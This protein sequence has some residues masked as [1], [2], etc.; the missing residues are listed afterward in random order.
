[1]LIAYSLL[2]LLLFRLL[3]LNDLRSGWLFLSFVQTVHDVLVFLDH[4]LVVDIFEAELTVVG[5][6]C[7]L[8]VAA[9]PTYLLLRRRAR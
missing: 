6:S 4:K 5:D 3:L 9:L 8:Y 2:L 7:T 1:M